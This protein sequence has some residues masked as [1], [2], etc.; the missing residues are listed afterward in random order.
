MKSN[1]KQKALLANLNKNLSWPQSIFHNYKFL[2][3]LLPVLAY[4][5]F[6][7]RLFSHIKK[8]F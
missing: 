8:L 3:F 5:Y 6:R 2:W 4:I 7:Y 1:L